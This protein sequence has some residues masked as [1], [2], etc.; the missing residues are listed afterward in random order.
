VGLDLDELHVA[1]AVAVSSVARA[2]RF[3]EG[4]VWHGCWIQ[5]YSIQQMRYAFAMSNAPSRELFFGLVSAVGT[6]LNSVTNKLTELLAAFD[7]EVHTLR[8]ADFLA[9]FGPYKTELKQSPADEYIESH[10]DAGDEL[11]LRTKRPDALCVLALDEVAQLRAAN[12]SGR[13]AFVFRSIKNPGELERLQSIYGDSFY[14]IAAY[15]SHERRKIALSNRISKSRGET[16][17]DRF[18]SRAEQLMWRDQSGPGEK[19]GQLVSKVFHRADVFVDVSDEEKL[20][21]SLDRFLRLVFGDTLQT[22]TKQEYS[23]FAA[24]AAA[25]RSSELG[26][27]VGAAIVNDEGDVIALGAN[28][29]PKAGG[30]LYWPK[31]EPDMR[32]FH[33]GTDSNDEHKR[34]LV[35]DTLKRLRDAGWLAEDIKSKEPQDLTEIA[36]KRDGVFGKESRIANLIEFGRA[37]HGE[38]AAL[39]DA[40]RRGVSV[41]GCTMYVTTFPCHL[42]ARHIVAAG[43]KTVVYVEPYPKSLTAELYPD[44]IAVE[45]DDTTK[46]VRFAPFVGISP[47]QYL[48]LFE[49]SERKNPTTGEVLRLDKRLALP[50]YSKAEAAYLELEKSVLKDLLDQMKRSPS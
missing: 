18:F 30:G 21:E 42:C 40:A 26:R 36:V 49:A 28:E 10:M 16:P 20:G 7:Y 14:S 9:P 3:V 22:P 27:Q 13:R 6:D 48:R 25:L 34:S 37:V 1:L 15:A 41:Q 44:S 17:P 45:I 23:M 29:V 4:E 2:E 47:S 12:P 31:D 33:A 35:T 24:K 11:R 43:I 50:R 38:M 39:T 8:L 32:Q 46:L 5:S 19:M